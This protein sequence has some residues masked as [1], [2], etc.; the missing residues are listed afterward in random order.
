MGSLT[1]WHGTP[2]IRVRGV[3]FVVKDVSERE[4]NDIETEMCDSGGET[5]SDGGSNP[6]MCDSGGETTSD[7]GSTPIEVK[8]SYMASNLPQTIATCVISSFTERSLH[9][10][11]QI[12]VPT[13]LM[14]REQFRVC[15]YDCERDVLLISE[16]KLLATKEQL[17]RSAVAFLWLVINHR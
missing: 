1:T 3:E 16:P 12:V 9:P 14:A 15:L 17:S 4:K 6:E 5:T 2:D 11:K 10:H 8:Y 7:G 13:I